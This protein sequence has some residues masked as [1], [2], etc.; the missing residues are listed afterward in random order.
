VFGDTIVANPTE[1]PIFEQRLTIPDFRPE[2]DKEWWVYLLS[3][4]NLSTGCLSVTLRMIDPE[5]GEL[6]GDPFAGFLPPEDGTGRGQG[7]ISFSVRIDSDLGDGRLV[8]NRASIVFDTNNAIWTNEVLNTVGQPMHRLTVNQTGDGNGTV[9]STPAGID[10]GSDCQEEYAEGTEVQL[11][12]DPDAGS[13]FAGWQGDGD[14]SDGIVTLDADVTCIAVFDLQSFA[15]TVSRTGSGTGT[16]TSSPP[17]IDCGSDCSESYSYAT[18]V[19]LTATPSAGSSFAGWQGDNDCSDGVVTID[20]DV[21]CTAVFDLQSFALTVSRTGSG[22]GTVTSS[23]PGIDCGSDC[24]ESYSYA[25][26]VTLT[27]EPS[28]GSSFAGWQGDG[29]C[30]DGVVIIDAD[31]TCTAVFDLQPVLLPALIKKSTIDALTAILPTGDRGRDIRIKLSII[32]VERSLDEDLWEEPSHL[33]RKGKKVFREEKS[34]VRLLLRIS[35]DADI[36][37]EVGKIGAE[38]IHQLLLADQI[39]AKIAIDEAVEAAEQAGCNDNYSSSRCRRIR[40]DIDK[41]LEAWAAA[42]SEVEKGTFDKAI[43]RYGKAWDKAQKAMNTIIPKRS[44]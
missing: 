4:L 17:G 43:D 37:E 20:T 6:P 36:S 3:R 10:C 41:A 29:D 32:H 38:V 2:E 30:S 24:S 25:T 14:C 28:A 34:A 19:T 18:E 1:A 11:F 42:E 8:R 26:E 21:S 40:K 7:H 31:V 27:A 13:T 22:T 5:T 39:L 35:A 23:P 44:R 33:S 9:T 15:L 12:A 16:V